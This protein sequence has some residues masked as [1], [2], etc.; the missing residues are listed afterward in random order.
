MS[1][2]PPPWTNREKEAFA[3]HIAA[4]DERIRLLRARTILTP[5]YRI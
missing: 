4:Q 5:G 1:R 2:Q 3:R